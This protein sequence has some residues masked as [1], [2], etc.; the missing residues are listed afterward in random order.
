VPD[1][2]ALQTLQDYPRWK[3]QG[4]LMYYKPKDFSKVN[5]G[6]VDP[7]GAWVSHTT[8]TF[9]YFYD[10]A[11]L[12]ASGLPVP[13]TA[14]DLAKPVYKGHI[15]SPWPHDD[16][17]TLFVYSQ[18]IDKYGWQWVAGM[19]NNSI[20]LQRGSNTPGEAVA[21]KKAAIGLGGS[22][23]YGV[24]TVKTMTGR[25]A[26]SPYLAWGQRMSIIKKARHPAAAKLFL[27]WAISKEVQS[28]TLSAIG[29]RTDV[30]LTGAP[31]PWDVPL[32]SVAKFPVFMEDRASI[33]RLKATLALYFGEV[34]GEPS[35]GF[36]GLYPGK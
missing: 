1:V 15:A 5:P 13:K 31:Q 16:D 32:A 19:A 7:E 23:A 8:F 18:L 36:L 6:Y 9:S 22:T 21:A 11:Q 35:P 12:N 4:K 26:T 24:S 34:Q 29:S 10:E 17:A 2:I 20:L 14:E 27:N 28:T 25:E 3:K 33:E 30:N